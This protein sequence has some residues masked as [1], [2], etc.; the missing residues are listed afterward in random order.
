ERLAF[1]ALFVWITTAV[2]ALPGPGVL[3]DVTIFRTETAMDY[4]GIM[5]LA[6]QMIVGLEGATGA[7]IA[8]LDR[9]ENTHQFWVNTAAVLCEKTGDPFCEEDVRFMTA[10]TEP[11]GMSRIIEYSVDG[12]AKRVCAVLPPVETIDPTYVAEAFGQ[13]IPAI[14]QTPG[15]QETAAWL[16]LYHAAHCLD[17]ELSEIEDERAAT[18]ATLGLAIL[19]G[20]PGFTPGIHRADWRKLAVM[21][22]YGSAYWGAGIAERVF[23]DMWKT[24][25]AEEIRA[26]LNC[27]ITVVGN[28]SIDIESIPRDTKIP[29]D[30]RCVGPIDM[31]TGQR[32]TGGTGVVSDSNLW[33]WMYGTGGVDA[34]PEPYAYTKLFASMQLAARYALDTANQLTLTSSPP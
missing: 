30:E 6:M 22:G 26:T 21:S 8:I 15:T 19:Q 24:E 9:I 18:F 5:G 29:D 20:H 23:L 16:S 25:A 12:K 3:F 4:S 13:G 28:T 17:G 7:Q 14:G 2:G 1:A 27:D 34:P 31:A 11:A 33:I 10:N 32:T